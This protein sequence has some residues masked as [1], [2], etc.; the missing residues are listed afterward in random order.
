VPADARPTRRYQAGLRVKDIYV[1]RKGKCRCGCGRWLPG[2]RRSWATDDCQRRAVLRFL[3]LKGDAPIIRNALRER[4]LAVCGRCHQQCEVLAC[5]WPRDPGHYLNGNLNGVYHQ[6]TLIPW[7]AHHVVPVVEGGAGC[8][9]E[10]YQTLC[11][12]CHHLE[13]AQLARRRAGHR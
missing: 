12:D 5:W 11:R 7:E 4:D 9:L 10:G 3:I 8:D 2:R 1:P 13:T 6:E